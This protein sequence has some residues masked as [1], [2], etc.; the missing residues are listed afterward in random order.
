M[1]GPPRTR[2]Y[3]A[4]RSA[5]SR[6]QARVGVSVALVFVLVAV[7]ADFLA[8]PLPLLL[9]MDGQLYVLPNV[10]RPAALRPYDNQ[11]LAQ[12]LAAAD[13][14]V[15]PVVAWGENSHDLS[16]VLEAPSHEHWLGTDSAG[17]DVFARLV[18]GARVSLT[19]AALSVLLMSCIGVVV[20]LCAG[21]FGGLLDVWLM[22]LVDALHAVPAMLLLITLLQLLRP[23][24]FASVL[25]MTA[26]IGCVRWTEL[27]R[28]VRAEVLRV[29]ATPYIEAARALG[30][31]SARIVRYHVLPNV[32]S[33]VLVAASFSMAGAIVIEG[34]LSFLGFGV[35]DD[36]ASW[37]SLL[38]EVRDHFDAW[39]LAVFPGAAMFVSVGVY[40][41]LGE[42][43]RDALDPQRAHSGALHEGVDSARQM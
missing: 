4:L 40:N 36:V 41:L 7:F 43:V 3:R 5:F 12:R 19:V 35:P 26:V 28:L 42:A 32:M 8:S 15:F 34:A 17:R 2:S 30:L 13:W 18:H 16:A 38:N 33:P 21:Y 11:L 20:G 1:P 25:T 39:W 9:R 29:R 10:M 14:A 31:G 27:S 24:G 6:P 37:G 23:T 22:R